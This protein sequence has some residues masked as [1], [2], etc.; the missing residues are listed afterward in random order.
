[1]SRPDNYTDAFLS[2][3]VIRSI[4]DGLGWLFGERDGGWPELF[5][6]S[7]NGKWYATDKA[8]GRFGRWVYKGSDSVNLASE[9]LRLALGLR[10]FQRGDLHDPIVGK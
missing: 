5:H 9:E 7:G 3:E 10:S 1:M 4:A 2:V 6:P 8:G